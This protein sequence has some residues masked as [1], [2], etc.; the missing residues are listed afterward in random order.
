[1]MIL[2]GREAYNFSVIYSCS[3]Y[4]NKV[5][6]VLHV[7][8]TNFLYIR[9]D[10]FNFE[11]ACPI[12]ARQALQ[13]RPIE[14]SNEGKRRAT[15]QTIEMESVQLKLHEMQQSIDLFD[16]RFKSEYAQIESRLFNCSDAYR[17]LHA[18]YKAPIPSVPA[19]AGSP[20]APPSLHQSVILTWLANRFPVLWNHLVNEFSEH[21]QNELNLDY[22]NI[23]SI[24]N[25]IEEYE[26]IESDP[27]IRELME[28]L[29][30]QYRV[31]TD[32]YSQV[33]RVALQAYTIIDVKNCPKM[34]ENIKSQYHDVVF[35][36]LPLDSGFLITFDKNWI[37]QLLEVIAN[38][39]IYQE[40]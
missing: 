26:N 31:S 25:F 11:K 37:I 15:S 40:Y 3:Y 5:F 22:E 14:L 13:L 9:I 16:K 18:Q 27:V 29:A 28:L 2:F 23:R 20:D 32:H 30:N 34:T 17:Q 7:R 21:I 6:Y 19:S 39:Q 24:Y 33:L 38:L 36:P 4:C 12:R 35:S 1:M 8:I 10:I